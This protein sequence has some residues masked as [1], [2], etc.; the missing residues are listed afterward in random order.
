MFFGDVRIAS[1]GSGRDLVEGTWTLYVGN[2]D[3]T[4]KLYLIFS[5]TNLDSIPTST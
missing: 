4:H 2:S 3:Q 5:Y 1:L